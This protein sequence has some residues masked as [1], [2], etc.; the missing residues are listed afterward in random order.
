MR[1]SAKLWAVLF[2][3]Q[4]VA[5]WALAS[6]THEQAIVVTGES[7][8]AL[9]RQ[10]VATN[11]AM[12]KARLAGAVTADGYAQWRTFGRKFQAAYP[13][14]LDLWR[15]ADASGD[16]RLQAQAA[17]MLAALG[18]DL[19]KWIA[20]VSSLHSPAPDGGP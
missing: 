13:L 9:G 6:C 15:A 18:A 3:F 20:L 16:E 7:L 12:T 1:H 14:A 17:A 2:V 4:P 19:S 8:D 10:F 5:W 11:D